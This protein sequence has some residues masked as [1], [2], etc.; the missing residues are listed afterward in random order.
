MQ[1]GSFWTL[2]E[3]SSVAL[4]APGGKSART[5]PTPQELPN[6]LDIEHRIFPAFFSHCPLV[7]E[8]AEAL[9]F[10]ILFNNPMYISFFYSVTRLETAVHLN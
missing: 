2:L 1:K 5:I 10:F 4:E 6:H 8:V 3:P 7:S 9:A